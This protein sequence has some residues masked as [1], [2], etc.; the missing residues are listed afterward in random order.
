MYV[1]LGDVYRSM[2]EDIAGKAGVL[3][4]QNVPLVSDTF[5]QTHTHRIVLGPGCVTH[6]VSLSSLRP[7]TVAA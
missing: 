3:Y 7:H 2:R 4:A 1:V 6:S 5:T